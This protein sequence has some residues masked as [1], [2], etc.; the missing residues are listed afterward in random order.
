MT[1]V[2]V[3][4]M[5]TLFK[6]GLNEMTVYLVL[7][8]LPWYCIKAWRGSRFIFP[9]SLCWK[10]SS[11]PRWSLQIILKRDRQYSLNES[12]NRHR[13]IKEVK[14]WSE[15]LLSKQPLVNM[16]QM[17]LILPWA[18]ENEHNPMSA[19]RSRLTKHTRSGE[20]N[21]LSKLCSWGLHFLLT[22]PPHSIIKSLKLCTK[23][24]CGKINMI[25][26]TH[27]KRQICPHK[28]ET[29]PEVRRYKA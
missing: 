19:S 25:I 4:F 22:L 11:G 14:I 29:L 20:I 1:L 8:S 2:L 24:V 17:C 5:A 28:W 12:Q 7:W 13:Q 10:C 21:H 18:I 9:P 16:C 3:F 23:G 6:M 15:V 26:L 27:N